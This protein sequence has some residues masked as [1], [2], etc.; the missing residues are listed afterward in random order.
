M[1]DFIQ[2]IPNIHRWF[3]L[4]LVL[5]AVISYAWQKFSLELTSLMAIAAM[6]IFFHLF[7]LRDSLG[8][9]IMTNDRLLSG[10]AN[11][12][13][14]TV[15]SLLV[16][17]QAIVQTGALNEVANWILHLSRNSRFL[18]LGITFFVV[19]TISAFLNNTP[20]VVIFIP[21][22]AAMARGLSLSASKVM[23]PLSFASILGGMVTLI[24]S[25][26]NLLV[27]GIVS[28]LGIGDMSFFEF[29]KPG[30]VL[31]TIG[32]LYILFIAPYFLKDRTS[33]A[34]EM[35]AVDEE[36]Q[37]HFV[38]QIDIGFE[39]DLLGTLISKGHFEGFD[40]LTIRMVQ[41]GERAY[42][43]P[44]D[45]E[46]IIQPRDMLVLSGNRKDL[47][48]FF[49]KHPDGLE[50]HFALAEELSDSDD[51][52]EINQDMHI[53]EIVVAPASRV[54]G[55]TLSQIGFHREYQSVVLG[56]QRQTRLIRTR[57]NDIR[58]AAGDVL[59][60]IGKNEDI[61]NLQQS[62]D[63]LLLEWSTEEIHAGKKAKLAASIFGG[64]IALSAAGI[65]PIVTSSLCGVVLMLL[66]NCLNLRQA[67]RALDM[68]IML[69]I[70]TSIALGISMQET[71]AAQYLA[72][73]YVSLFE[74]APPIV[75]MG[76]LFILMVV[77]TDI[78]S[79]NAS[80]VLCTPIAVSIAVQLGVDPWIFIFAV[81]FACNSSFATPIGYQTNL[82]VMGPGHYTFADFMRS[83]IPITLL[84]WVGYMGYAK[85]VYGL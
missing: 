14:I 5:L 69:L 16:L 47:M 78:L 39:S 15:L 38:A 80:A 7:P 54:I 44:Y 82:M 18:S 62:K 70:G 52:V 4:G 79:N 29:S 22:M 36:N 28:D 73:A 8:N 40:D 66:T 27:A 85:F 34:D 51:E 1:I 32:F 67:A 64:V 33:L 13:L 74:G 61:L 42:L 57:I 76:A 81:I 20:V 26:T 60:I 71:G 31:A 53:A 21:I 41:R 75:I 49:A 68:K 37:R 2:D 43:P 19:I 30:L 10:L 58:L 84:I 50:K 72:D 6:L 56:I 11:P 25:S 3:I 83:G 77:L 24:G 55:Q 59:L 65:L 9:D 35:A 12:A 17:G 48:A 23:I 46:M 45:E 63:L